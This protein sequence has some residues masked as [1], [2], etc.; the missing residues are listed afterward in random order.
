VKWF[1]H[2]IEMVELI[3]LFLLVWTIVF[4]IPLGL[5]VLARLAGAT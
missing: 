4:G 5:G 3:G 2:F 1:Y